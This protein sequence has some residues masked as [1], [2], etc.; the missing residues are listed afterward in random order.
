[1]HL[2]MSS[3]S[4]VIHEV[5][6]KYQRKRSFSVFIHSDEGLKLDASFLESFTAAN[7]PCLVTRTRRKTLQICIFN[8]KKNN[9]FAR[10]A[11]AFLIL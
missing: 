11:R 3:A 7:V 9:S 1:M 8:E 5:E 10:T 2:S 4:S 6:R